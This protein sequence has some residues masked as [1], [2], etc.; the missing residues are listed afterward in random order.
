MCSEWHLTEVRWWRAFLNEDRS[1]EASEESKKESC[2][3]GPLIRCSRRSRVFFRSAPVGARIRRVR[4][5]I[6]RQRTGV[7]NVVAVARRAPSLF[8]SVAHCRSLCSDSYSDGLVASHIKGATWLSRNRAQQ[9]GF[10]ALA[11]NER[12]HSAER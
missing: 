5:E 8:V 3:S 9:G 10:D 1:N 12:K 6:G 2:V 7:S 11:N 4:S